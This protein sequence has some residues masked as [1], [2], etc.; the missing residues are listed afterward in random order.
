M[1]TDIFT[2]L[3][4]LTSIGYHIE[5]YRSYAVKDALHIKVRRF[6]PDL[7]ISRI[8]SYQDVCLV[9]EKPDAILITTIQDM[10][11]QIEIFIE[12]NEDGKGNL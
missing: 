10:V 12:E 11:K 7:V 5:F 1:P 2:F 4:N 3:F 8:V 6:D 9:K